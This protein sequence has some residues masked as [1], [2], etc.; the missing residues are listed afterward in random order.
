MSESQVCVF[1]HT[2]HGATAADESGVGVKAPLWNR[3]IPAGSTYIPYTSASLDA[4]VIQGQLDQPGGSSK[5]CLSCHDGT[6]AI[7]NVNVLDGQGGAPGSVS[8]PMQ[9]TG[10]GGTM[11]AGAGADSGFTRNLGVDLRNDH[12]I[13]LTYTE[14]LALRDGELRRVDLNQRWPPGSGDV[15]GVRGPG[16][17]PRLPLEPTAGDGRGQVQCAT[18]HDPHL[19]DT[20]PTK[21]A[22]KFLRGERFQEA[23]PS[24]AGFNAA[25]DVI[26]MGCHDKNLD[27]AAWANSAHAN[28]QVA[29]ETY[30]ATAAAQREFPNGLPVWK[31]SCLNCHDT[32]TVPGARR[33]TREG[34]DSPT[35]PKQGG[36]PALEETCYQCHTV[37]G[38]SALSSVTEVPNI[39]T[40]FA[41][42]RRMPITSAEQGTVGEPHDIGGNF[43]DPGFIDC[44]SP[45]NRC[46]ADFIE[47]RQRLAQRHAECTDCHNPHRVVKK[48]LATGNTA[49]PDAAGT[50]LHSNAGAD[51][52]TNLASGVL[53]GSWGVEPVY[54]SASFQVLPSSYLVKRGDPGNSI[55]MTVSAPYVTREYQVCL[56]CHSDYGYPDNNLYPI[57]NR[58]NL[59]Y[60]GGT[61]SGTNG[62]T[63][64]TNQAKEFQAPLAHQGETT[65][66]DSGA[67]SNFSTNNHRSWHP[68]IGSTGRTAGVRTMT[69]TANMFFAPWSNAGGGVAEVG[70]QTMYCSDC[71][72]SNTTNGTVVPVGGE[73]GAAWGPHGSSNDFILKGTWSPT[74]GAN[75]NTDNGLCF[76]CHNPAAYATAANRGD[77]GGWE[78]GFGNNSRDTNLHAFHADRLGR[79]L[80][81]MWCHVAVPHGWKNKA[82]LVNLND[83]GP[84]AGQAP[85]TEVSI[86]GNASVYNQEPYYRNAKL[87]I[88]S[89]ARSGQWAETNC[90][91]R[92]GQQGT[93]RDWMRNVCDNPP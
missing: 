46:G 54:G 67:G 41:L 53:R 13:S 79:N 12:P 51:I 69:N 81:C 65:T 29:N 70:N 52:H 6:L 44:S 26:C 47:P 59:G 4:N 36:S 63:Q 80:R 40:D 50:H 45:T 78:S 49:S 89:F 39:E 23:T 9:G 71:H 64:Y 11:P 19:H 55:D 33:L 88:I 74:T 22:Q 3:R 48:R 20:D 14:S 17:K 21:G 73:N 56:K 24:A 93:G 7:G 90:G 86:T 77:R 38:A 5:L 16:F 27:V 28:P 8:I 15:I 66:T 30:T 91:S 85:G 60:L 92:S 35:T 43:A 57:G 37:A 68:V 2:P 31:A 34:T 83:V 18:C 25:G 10:P 58:P 76:K 32:H 75:G 84:E 72:G 61:P 87:K 42:A 1:C 82:L 62:L